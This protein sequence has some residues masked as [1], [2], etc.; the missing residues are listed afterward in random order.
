MN[1]HRSTKGSPAVRKLSS[2]R[3]LVAG[4]IVSAHLG[5]CSADSPVGQTSTEVRRSSTSG[6]PEVRPEERH[7]FALEQSFPG[8]GGFGI[9]STGRRHVWIGEISQAGAA[10]ERVAAL[11]TGGAQSGQRDASFAGSKIGIA[12]YTFSTLARAR[13]VISDD[14]LSIETGIVEVSID[15]STNRVAVGVL[16]SHLE[17]ATRLVAE[18]LGANSLPAASVELRVVSLSQADVGK[19]PVELLQ[20]SLNT[21]LTA[22][23][24]P[25]VGG[26]RQVNTG[27]TP[28]TIGLIVHRSGSS[29]S[30]SNSH[31][32]PTTFGLDAGYQIFN[33]D[34]DHL[35]GQE[36]VDPVALS[37]SVCSVTPCRYSDA[38]YYAA[39]DTV[40]LRRGAIARPTGYSAVWGTAGPLAVD[41]T[42]RF[43]SVTSTAQPGQVSPGHYLMKVGQTTGWTEGIVLNTCLDIIAADGYKRKC[44]IRSKYYSSGGDSGAPVFLSTA[45]SGVML[46]GLHFGSNAGDQTTFSSHWHRV[47]EEL[48]G[49]ITAVTD[50]T[51]G[52]PAVS[53]TVDGGLPNLSWPAV[54]TSN[55][56]LPTTYHVYRWTYNSINGWTEW[57]AHVGTTQLLGF[58]DNSRFSDHYYGQTTPPSGVDYV[59]YQVVAENH[60]VVNGAANVYFRTYGTL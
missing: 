42:L 29:G 14:L 40:A 37:F 31:C 57:Q 24:V 23:H 41:Q 39:E 43:F 55:T 51:V 1:R 59:R 18:R 28:C 33:G 47:V 2:W 20:S 32:T 9:D 48:G 45:G 36:L 50:I 3:I 44:A 38:V 58:V 7:L 12:K 46:A 53:G 13:D 35:L 10:T 5:A 27:A 21:S 4:A 11:Y 56:I 52:A 17:S 15:G 54:A 16:A 22:P 60:G 26:V 19:A 6:A 49:Q 34:M 25:A 8:F 30:V